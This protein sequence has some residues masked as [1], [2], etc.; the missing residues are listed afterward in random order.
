[1]LLGG[2][3]SQEMKRIGPTRVLVRWES[4]LHGGNRPLAAH[5][6]VGYSLSYLGPPAGTVRHEIL[7]G[8]P[9]WNLDSLPRRR[10]P[11]AR[12]EGHQVLRGQNSA[13]PCAVLL[14]VPLPRRPESEEA[15]RW[16]LPRFARWPAQGRGQ[17]APARR[18][19]AQSAAPGGRPQDAA[20]GQ[21]ARTGGRGL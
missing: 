13:R 1:M 2:S 17:R 7:R 20:Q 10:C 12:S 16:T 21:V 11:A 15:P 18:P 3:T 6:L 19:A 14:S 9:P 5:I 4:V 8:P